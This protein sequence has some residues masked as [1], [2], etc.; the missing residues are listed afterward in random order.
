MRVTSS[1]ISL[2]CVDAW[3]PS[4]ILHSTCGPL[5]RS[6]WISWSKY[7][8]Y[9]IFIYPKNHKN[10]FLDLP[11]VPLLNPIA[12]NL[13]RI[14]RLHL[15]ALS[16]LSFSSLL[17]AISN[18]RITAIESTSTVRLQ[19]FFESNQISIISKFTYREFKVWLI[20]S[21]KTE[22]TNF[23]IITSKSYLLI[24]TWDINIWTTVS[25]TVLPLSWDSHFNHFPIFL[26]FCRGCLT[27][28]IY[29]PLR[30][31]WFNPMCMSIKS[32]NKERWIQIHAPNFPVPPCQEYPVPDN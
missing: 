25:V 8:I 1:C 4:L 5:T 31:H 32:L 6:A 21:F 19:L 30:L 20:I 18:N 22:D 27:P 14:S 29:H 24:S 2:K 28:L 11:L 16:S 9:L 26:L 13:S 7:M 23:I 17:K 3:F 10:C 15:R 12:N